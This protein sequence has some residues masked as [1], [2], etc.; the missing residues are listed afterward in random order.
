MT[1]PLGHLTN[2]GGPA[3][4]STAAS[5]I[6]AFGRSN[7]PESYTGLTL[8]ADQRSLMVYRRPSASFDTELHHILAGLPVSVHDAR[9]SERAMLAV[10]ERLGA[11]DAYWREQGLRIVAFGP[12]HDGTG[13]DL[14]TPDVELAQRLLP[15]RYDLEFLIVRGGPVTPYQTT[16]L[17]PGL[18]A[19]Q[20]ANRLP[21]RS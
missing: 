13:I 3:R 7:H 4:L 10:V 1:N 16:R 9:Y 11:D 2:P 19:M 12:R 17:G 8:D 15:A 18:P 6:E 21:R 20:T 14:T 5:T